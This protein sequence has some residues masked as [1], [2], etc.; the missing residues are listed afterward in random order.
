MRPE[1]RQVAGTLARLY[2]QGGDHE[3]AGY[4]AIM[5]A[6]IGGANSAYMQAQMIMAADR[7]GWDAY[8]YA[9]A[10]NR[11]NDAVVKF[12]QV[13]PYRQTLAVDETA[14]DFALAGRNEKEQARA[15]NNLGW[16]YAALGD[17]QKALDYYEQALLLRQVGD[18]GEATTL[19]DI[20]SVYADL[21]EKQKALDY[22]E[23]ALPLGGRWATAAARRPPSPTSAV[24]MPTWARSRRRWTSTS[25]RC[26]CAAGGRPRRRGG[27]PQQHRQCLCR[28]GRQAE[29]AGLLRAGAAAVRQ[30][31]D[32]GGEATTLT[33][34]GSVYA[35]LGEKQ[36][37]LD[38]YEQALPLYRQVGDKGGE[39]TT[40]NNIGVVY[41]ALGE[42]QKALAYYEQA[43]PLCRQ[44]GD[45]GGEATTLNNL[46]GVYSALGEKQKA[47]DYYEQA[48]PL[49]RQ[50]GDKGGEA[51]TLNNLGVVYAALG[52]K[53]K[54]LAYY[55]QA[56]PLI[57]Q[58]GDKGG[59]AATLNNLGGVYAALG[60]KQKA[61]AYYERALP[62][63]EQVGGPLGEACVATT[64]AGSTSDL[65]RPGRGRRRDGDSCRFG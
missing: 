28:P 48:L 22:Y 17:K 32:R 9:Y 14:Y 24:S 65:G 44:V 55:E 50:V 62:L 37:A 41:D 51:T 57:R 31:G 30:V 13:L 15:M 34:I 47:L 23:Q 10:A 45:K 4:Y 38:Y 36:K 29:G 35:A 59:E 19:T 42:K 60:D 1:V 11:L 2:E 64:S 40:L 39:A 49:C 46:G 5:A 18:G 16:V 21:G 26:R 54:A 8:D 20:G 43:L 25:R 63:I 61:L 53:Q 33:N 6:N 56:L 58:V 7:S 52:D 3:Q 27:D 12:Y